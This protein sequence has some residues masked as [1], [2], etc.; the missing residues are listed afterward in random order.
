M[1]GIKNRQHEENNAQTNYDRQKYG[2]FNYIDIKS[3]H[4]AQPE[5]LGML[6]MTWCKKEVSFV[7]I[8]EPKISM[9]KKV[10]TILGTKVRVISWIWVTD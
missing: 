8:Q 1:G 4:C 3:N 9:A 10:T 2:K 7:S 5:I 6:I